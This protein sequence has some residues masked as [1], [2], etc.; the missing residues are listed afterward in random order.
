MTSESFALTKRVCSTLT[1]DVCLEWD[2]MT[3]NMQEN[4]VHCCFYDV[5]VR[6]AA[7]AD[8]VY[9]PDME[10]PMNSMSAVAA[11]TTAAAS[12]KMEAYN[13]NHKMW[14]DFEAWWTKGGSNYAR[15]EFLIRE[16][17]FGMLDIDIP[18]E[19]VRSLVHSFTHVVLI[20]DLIP[21]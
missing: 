10:K 15:K 21:S 16:S 18:E 1:E 14:I 6:K 7:E 11:T 8:H 17:I 12:A 13:K 4:E 3:T 9:F 20:S 19:K 5:Y 2:R